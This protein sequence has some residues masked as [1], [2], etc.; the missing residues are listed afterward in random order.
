MLKIR[1]CILSLFLGFAV[2]ANAQS[3]FPNCGTA[4]TYVT[5]SEP[6]DYCIPEPSIT[7]QSGNSPWYANTQNLSTCLGSTPQSTWKMLQIAAP[8]DLLI[9][10][11]Q[12]SQYNNTT[13]SPDPS[14]TNRDI[15]FACWGPFPD[16]Y[17]GN[18]FLTKLRNG[19]FTLTS[20]SSGSHRPSNGVHTQDPGSNPPTYGGY[21]ITSPNSI[22]L[23]DCSYNAAATEWCFIPNAQQGDWYLLL[24]CNYSQQPGFFSFTTVTSS[25][26]GSTNCDLLNC[27][28]SN[29]PTPCEGN[30][31]TLYCTMDPSELPSN[32]QFTWNAP[33]GTT[34][35]TTN[36]PSYT[37]VAETSMTGQ[38]EVVVNTNPPRHGYI[39]IAVQ[40]TPAVIT[41]SE[42]VIC[43]GDSIILRTPY[44]DVYTSDY[45]GYTRW[46][47]QNQ[48]GS[49]IGT[50]TSL[51]VYPTEDC[52][53]ILKVKDGL[54]ECNNAD[55]ISI[56]VNPIPEITLVAG[57]TNLCPG[58]QT[59][60]TA[61]CEQNVSYRWSNGATTATITAEPSETRTYT[62][63]V[64]LRDGAQCEKDSSIV[65]H[66]DEN[67][68]LRYET[69]PSHCGQRTGGITM[70]ATGGDGT[71]TFS[72]N[73]NTATFIDSIASNLLSGSYIVTA[74][75]G[76]ACTQSI[77][78]EVPSIPGPTP[79][80]LFTSNDNVNM[81]ITNCTQGANNNY[82]WDFGDGANSTETHPVHEY[83]EPGLY[84]V[85]LTVADDFNCVDSLRQDYKINGPVYI[86]NAFSPNGDGVNDELFVIG[87]TIQKEEFFWAVYD[88]HGTLVFLSLDPTIGW[89]GTIHAGKNKLKD[90]SPGV[91]VYRLK[92][93]DVNGNY[94]ERDGSI[95]LIR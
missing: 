17:D 29:N 83:M 2:L 51:V 73:P 94:F 52:N 49:P 43:K 64:K 47:Y 59:Q 10:I 39:D 74:T 79:C 33:D 60:I 77:T 86:P 41:A 87:K 21:P 75:D 65:I 42:T 76:M 6:N 13:C 53:Y 23:V 72:S 58:E 67:I 81:I 7:N 30:E 55:T 28:D 46:F 15:D 93:K 25:S 90:A 9:Y 57:D 35:A 44:R 40:Q 12:F 68:Q 11:Q 92:Y 69:E 14:S 85:S 70:H 34:L 45:E 3:C 48:D 95:T 4:F 78:V 50:D 36:T 63:N 82:F 61:T 31:F 22:P 80:F 18:D 62:V 66:V 16:V 24:I 84:S 32:P 91:Y 89:D 54:S 88:R 38:F 27:L 19:T 56:T 37:L 26:T 20:G 8:G 5:C 1:I 71:F